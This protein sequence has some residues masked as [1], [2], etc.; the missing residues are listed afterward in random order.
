M[1]VSPPAFQTQV[2]QIAQAMPCA[3]GS[4]PADNLGAGDHRYRG[5]RAGNRL[6]GNC[7]FCSYPVRLCV[8]SAY[9]LVAASDVTDFRGIYRGTLPVRTLGAYQLLSRV[10][11]AMHPVLSVFIWAGIPDFWFLS[12]VPLRG[13]WHCR[14]A[15]WAVR[16]MRL[17]PLKNPD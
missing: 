4:V 6:R 8:P 7:L 2:A 9:L 11:M 3:C 16:L 10:G 5:N 17:R 12:I 13:C 15:G 1:G 14:F